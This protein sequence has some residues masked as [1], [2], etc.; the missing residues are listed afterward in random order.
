MQIRDIALVSHA[1]LVPLL[2]L[3]TEVAVWSVLEG[4]T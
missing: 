3:L 1:S 4:S 2:V